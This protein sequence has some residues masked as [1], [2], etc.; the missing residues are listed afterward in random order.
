[1]HRGH[2]EDYDLVRQAQKGSKKAFDLLMIKHQ[3][4]VFRK[5]FFMLKRDRQEAEEAAQEAF[6]KAFRNIK[7]FQGDSKFSTWLVVIA[8]NHCLNVLNKKKNS[9]IVDSNGMLEQIYAAYDDIEYYQAVKDCVRRKVQGLSAKYRD[10]IEKVHL[11][12]M[13]YAEAAESLGCSVDK[14]RRQLYRAMKKAGPLLKE[15]R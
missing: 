1:M 7:D 2:D 14:I 4:K 3:E 8:K 15:C 11:D 13:S 12:E 10:Y 6:L 5:C 9:P